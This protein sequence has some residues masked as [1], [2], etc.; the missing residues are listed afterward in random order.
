MIF[1]KFLSALVVL[2]VNTEI[3]WGSNASP[4]KVKR[5]DNQSCGLPSQTTSLIIGGNDFQRGAWPWMVA[6]MVKSTLPPK[7]FCGGVL[8]SST[9]VLTGKLK[10]KLALKSSNCKLTGLLF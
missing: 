4:S 1:K 7:L 8:V 10:H 9:K 3:V 2:L 5:N 6:L